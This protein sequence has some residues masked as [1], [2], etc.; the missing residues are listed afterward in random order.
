[1]ISLTLSLEA[2][3]EEFTIDVASLKEADLI[4]QPPFLVEKDKAA[5][6]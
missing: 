4:D 6:S 5:D 3:G 1:M 2:H